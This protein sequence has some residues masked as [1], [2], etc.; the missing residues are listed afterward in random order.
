MTQKE[1]DDIR[2][3]LN[4]ERRERKRINQQQ[5]DEKRMELKYRMKQECDDFYDRRSELL[6][7]KDR[8]WALRR[9]QLRNGACRWSDKVMELEQEERNVCRELMTTDEA[10]NNACADIDRQAFHAYQTLVELNHKVDEWFDRKLQ[11]ATNYE[12][13]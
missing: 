9:T 7:K 5:Y 2:Q 1:L 11:Q 13:A 12:C 8:L 10:H 3:K 4:Q 6:A